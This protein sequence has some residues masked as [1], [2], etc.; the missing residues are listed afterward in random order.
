[1]CLMGVAGVIEAL[2]SSF[3]QKLEEVG[4]RLEDGLSAEKRVILE[5]LEALHLDRADALIAKSLEV[6]IDVGRILGRQQHSPR[7]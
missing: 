5:E 7:L 2:S 3:D 1:M 6:G 4:T